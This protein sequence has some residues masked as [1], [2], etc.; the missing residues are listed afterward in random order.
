MRKDIPSTAPIPLQ[1]IGPV[2]IHGD[3]QAEVEIPLATFETP[4]WASCERGIKA[5]NRAGGIQITITDDQMTRSI[6][7]ESRTAANAFHAYKKIME[8]QLEIAA[9]CETTSRFLRFKSIHI[10]LVARLLYIRFS[11]TTADAS[12]HN[13]STIA[14]Q[15]AS[16]WITQH[17]ADLQY[18]SISGNICCDKKTS[19]INGIL[20]RG[21]SVIA[22]VT[23]SKRICQ[24]YFHCHP[25]EI[26]NLNIKKNLLGSILAGSVR[27]A[28]AHVAN[29]LL[30]F[31]LATG[32]DAANIVEGSQAITFCELDG[33]ALYF[34]VT[35][36]NLIVGTVGNGKD[37]PFVK[38]ILQRIECLEKK[39]TGSN[40]RRLSALAASAVLAGELS[41]LA[42]QV[43]PH[44]LT[45]A[46]IQIERKRG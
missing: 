42:S 29:M 15:K 20:G 6:I 23:L 16:D 19:A 26:V 31:Y 24:S 39:D 2:Y 13:M 28:N 45:Q 40:A 5:A 22:E 34:S 12:G 27:S 11:F 21:K 17:I 7:L 46:H 43:K 35:L 14:A 9:V 37:L 3:I 30:A 4:L 32:Q 41:L 8:N 10:E 25:Q 44:Q 1:W 18:I 38:E 33:D 36:P